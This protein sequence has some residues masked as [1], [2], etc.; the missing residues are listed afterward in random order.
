MRILQQ[1]YRVPLPPLSID[2]KATAKRFEL[3]P[4]GVRPQA[5]G[6]PLQTILLHLL[7]RQ[8][9]LEPSS[10]LLPSNLL[11]LLVEGS[12]L[13]D[14]FKTSFNGPRSGT[15]ECKP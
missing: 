9:E 6:V 1:K 2:C 4:V 13:Q 10:Y 12:R 5:V 8:L 7:G 15:S 11:C 3:G 14:C